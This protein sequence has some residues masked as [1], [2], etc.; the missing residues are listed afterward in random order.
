MKELSVE[1]K[2]KLYDKAIAHARLLLK[3]IGNATLGNLVLK[4]EFKTMF[5]ALEESEDERIRKTLIKYFRNCVSLEGINGEDISN[6]LEKQGEQKPADKVSLDF[7][8]GDILYEQ[9]TMS[10][11][12]VCERNG[13]WLMTFCDYWMLKE[14]LHIEFPYEKYGFVREMS[15]VPATK[16]QR[17]L[18]FQKMKE[19]G[20]E[21]DAEKKEMK[22]VEQK[23]AAWSEEDERFADKIVC[24]MKSS[25][26]GF[27][28][29]EAFVDEV[30]KWLKNKLK[31]LK[32]RVQ[33]H[34]AYYNNDRIDIEVWVTKNKQWI[35][36]LNGKV[37]R[38]QWGDEPQ[39]IYKQFFYLSEIESLKE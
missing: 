29:E 38:G 33:P 20:Y 26:N 15:L 30:D 31:S 19:A 6:W 39:C 14:K 34:N 35:L 18:L 24:V 21:W 27:P 22:K 1:E 7:K 10:I 37:V 32:D 4:N 13:S 2:A 17:D 36:K 25:A 12:L 28:Q 5:P 23:H 9:K 8:K 16:E 3:T 11:L